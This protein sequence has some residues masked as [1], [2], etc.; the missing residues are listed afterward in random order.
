MESS[1][2]LHS[3]SALKLHPPPA[4]LLYTH[5]FQFVC[6][7]GPYGVLAMG[8]TQV[9]RDV[10]LIGDLCPCPAPCP[11]QEQFQL[12]QTV[13]TELRLPP[14]RDRRDQPRSADDNDVTVVLLAE[15]EEAVSIFFEGKDSFT[16]NT[17]CFRL[18]TK[19]TTTKSLGRVNTASVM[20]N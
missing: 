4:H 2:L 3:S 15:T 9:R 18:R 16:F 10:R 5:R 17:F 8:T 14:T 20:L 12:L 1:R 7:V 13:L 11:V 6:R 19:Q